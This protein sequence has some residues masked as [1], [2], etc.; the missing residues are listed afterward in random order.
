MLGSHTL[1]TVS[2]S[3]NTFEG[4]KRIFLSNSPFSHWVS[5]LLEGAA[6]NRGRRMLKVCSNGEKR[7]TWKNRN[8]DTNL[9][10]CYS[11]QQKPH[12]DWPRVDTSDHRSYEATNRLSHDTPHPPLAQILERFVQPKDPR[13]LKQ[14]CFVTV[15]SSLVCPSSKTNM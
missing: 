9:F 6:A 8:I 7:M 14:R 10:Q 11:V 1:V 13:F 2:E 15:P 4:K 3:V 12:V 5:V